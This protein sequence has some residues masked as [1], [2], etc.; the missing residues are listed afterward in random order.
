MRKQFREMGAVMCM[1]KNTLMKKA[2]WELMEEDKAA[3]KERPQLKIIR[4]A[5]VLNVGLIFT[6]GD[7]TAIKKV[8][9]TQ[10]R[11]APAKVGSLAPSDVEVKAGPTGMDPKQTSFF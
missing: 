4:D 10:V 9:D 6:D 7:L 8:L 11:E 1:G 2:I 3:G 5:L